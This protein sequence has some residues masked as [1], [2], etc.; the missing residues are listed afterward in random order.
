MVWMIL[1]N[2]S[3]ACVGL[4]GW[5]S[6]WDEVVCWRSWIA[7][8]NWLVHIWM[9]SRGLGMGMGTVR[10]FHVTVSEIRSRWVPQ[11]HPR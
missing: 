1:W 5:W 7:C 10:G 8:F 6:E 2:W 4:L 11:T 3:S 9:V